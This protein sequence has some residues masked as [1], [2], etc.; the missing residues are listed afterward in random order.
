[1]ANRL[2]INSAPCVP[3]APAAD[4]KAA[5]VSNGRNGTPPADTGR[6]ADGRF[7]KGCPGG[8]GNPHLR[9]LAEFRQAFSEALT[10][11]DLA[12]VARVLHQ[13]AVKH[14]DTAAAKLLL[15]YY[16]GQPP[17][18]VDPDNVEAEALRQLLEFPGVMD[19]VQASGRVLP[20]VALRVLGQTL[21]VDDD[22]YRR[23]WQATL[24]KLQGELAALKKEKARLQGRDLDDEDDDLA[25]LDDDDGDDEDPD[26]EPN[27]DPPGRPAA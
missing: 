6:G 7:T 23:E 10:P 14:A 26:P 17:A 18:A 8:P 5:A 16:L 11:A 22:S 1:M 27:P 3:D 2:K 9:R 4:G 25:D 13:R 19:V 20:A 15:G 12:E 21:A 24:A